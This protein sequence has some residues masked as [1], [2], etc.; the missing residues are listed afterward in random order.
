M[1]AA[2]ARVTQLKAAKTTLETKNRML[3][4]L[5]ASL[6]KQLETT[7][8]I[9]L[10]LRDAPQGHIPSNPLDLTGLP[11]QDL[12]LVRTKLVNL[13]SDILGLKAHSGNLGTVKAFLDIIPNIQSVKDV[14]AWLT[15]AF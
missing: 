3:E 10:S 13:E 5:V 14:E 6:T 11:S 15:M 1:P 12:S 8:A 9:V 4:V 2:E 7:L